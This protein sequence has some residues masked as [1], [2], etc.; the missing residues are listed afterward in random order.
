MS[1]HMMLRRVLGLAFLAMLAMLGGC[2]SVPMGD[3]ALD[4]E[5]KKFAAPPADM[6]RLY[7][8]RNSVLGAALTKRVMV[9]GVYLGESAVK[10]YFV[11]DLAPGKH[12]LATQSEF[13]DNTLEL[14]TLGG[15]N[16]FVRQY[17]KLGVVVGGAN[18]E[19]MSD[20]EGMAGVKECQLAAPAATAATAA[21]ASAPPGK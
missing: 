4:A 9:D 13:S 11:K 6:S 15:R 19:V 17:I 5:A 10:T 7:V 8:Y 16:Y 14:E 3:K 1:V 2:A 21:P 20:E 18:L 12:T